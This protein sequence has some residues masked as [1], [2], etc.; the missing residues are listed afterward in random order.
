M[1]RLNVE[2]SGA[3]KGGFIDYT[4]ECTGKITYNLKIKYKIGFLT[5]SFSKNGSYKFNREAAESISYNEVGEITDLGH[6]TSAVVLLSNQGLSLVEIYSADYNVTGKAWINIH[7]SLISFRRIEIN[8]KINGI[9]VT[10]KA[11]E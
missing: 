3:I 10:V 5:N 2:K 11:N 9:S 8:G 4:I 6:N 7:S 1:P